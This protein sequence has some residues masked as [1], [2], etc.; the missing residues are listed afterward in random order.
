[1]RKCPKCSKKEVVND[2]YCGICRECTLPP[3]K[4]SRQRAL[5]IVNAPVGVLEFWPGEFFVI[6]SDQKPIAVAPSQELAWAVGVIINEP[7]HWTQTVPTESGSYWHWNGDE[8]SAP[9]HINIMWSGTDEKCFAPMGQYGWTEVQDVDKL[10][11]WW[12][13]LA[14]PSL[15]VVKG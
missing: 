11:G 14:V 1:M 4:M 5:E 10:A 12:M 9:I 6:G 13:L 3:V 7:A 15:P 8:D 2:G